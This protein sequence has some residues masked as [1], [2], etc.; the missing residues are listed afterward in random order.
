MLQPDRKQRRPC[1]ILENY[2]AT[3]RDTDPAIEANYT[4]LRIAFGVG[5]TD[6]LTFETLASGSDTVQTPVK[7]G[8][9]QKQRTEPENQEK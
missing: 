9:R 7:A 2:M 1:T 4:A 6:T 3:T 8:V 5:G